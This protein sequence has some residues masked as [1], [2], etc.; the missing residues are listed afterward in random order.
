MLWGG[1]G[2]KLDKDAHLLTL[3]GLAAGPEGKHEVMAKSTVSPL[4]CS[5]P[6][7]PTPLGAK[8]EFKVLS[9]ML[10]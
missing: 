6:G 10:F 9:S 1:G 7:L 5:S 8:G 3:C 4:D 2:F